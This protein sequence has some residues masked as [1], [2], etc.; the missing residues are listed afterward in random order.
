[1]NAWAGNTPAVIPSDTL[2]GVMGSARNPEV[3][4]KIYEIRG[5]DRSKPLIVLL[6]DASGLSEFGVAPTPMEKKIMAKYWPGPVT[7]VFSV[8]DPKFEYLHRGTHSIAFRVPNKRSLHELLEK[9]GPLV[10]PSANPEGKEP[11]HTIEEAKAYFGAS[12]SEY[13]DG[14]RL[15]G[16]ASTLLQVQDEKIRILRQGSTKIEENDLS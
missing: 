3:V 12:V 7:I 9:S 5:R 2:Y 13:I 15:E 10:A 14:G 16:L 8:P 1:M 11:A 6:P 4:E